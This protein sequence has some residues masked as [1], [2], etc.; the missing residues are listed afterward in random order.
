MI[1]G[2]RSFKEISPKGGRWTWHPDLGIL[3]QA[4]GKAFQWP[5]RRSCACH[6]EVGVS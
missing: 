4:V 3:R 2:Y 6:A 5:G 1:Q